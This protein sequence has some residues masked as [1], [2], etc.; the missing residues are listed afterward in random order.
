M[1]QDKVIVFTTI[2]I[3]V[4]GIGISL[5]NWLS[6]F[7]PIGKSPLKTVLVTDT[8][9]PEPT[10]NT[11]SIDP[12]TLIDSDANILDKKIVNLDGM[13]PEEIIINWNTNDI[14]RQSLDVF[15][16]YPDGGIKNALHLPCFV[17]C[18]NGPPQFAIVNLF[19]DNTRQLFVYHQVGSAGNLY[20][21][22]YKFRGLQSLERIYTSNSPNNKI[23]LSRTKPVISNEKI[24][25][26][27]AGYL[28][29]VKWKDNQLVLENTFIDP[30]SN[31]ITIEYW[32]TQNCEHIL[33]SDV[34]VI[35][36][37]GQTLTLNEAKNDPP[38]PSYLNIQYYSSDILEPRDP[39]MFFAKQTGET[40]IALRL[41]GI[42]D[43]YITIHVVE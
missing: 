14:E 9:G 15:A 8:P 33:T 37:V 19:N 31:N 23:D 39:N 40:Q 20:F 41:I 43:T 10:L 22:I 12:K 1:Q 13:G 4:A 18:I 35:M 2:L 16:Y 26:S 24:Y 6:P 25:F 5:F 3:G 27:Q 11:Y 17:G 7:E 29:E 21:E 34:E 42:D 32:C 38:V 28:N 30:G 36:K